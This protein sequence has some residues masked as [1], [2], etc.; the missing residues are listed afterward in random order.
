MYRSQPMHLVQ[1]RNHVAQH[2]SSN[3]TFQTVEGMI[4]SSLELVLELISAPVQS[5]RNIWT[6]C[7]LFRDPKGGGG[8]QHVAC[9]E[10]PRG[11]GGVGS[12]YLMR[13]NKYNK[14]NPVR[15][16]AA[17]ALVH[18]PLPKVGTQTRSADNS[19]FYL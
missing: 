14:H 1:T 4:A 2:E 13:G 12:C 6:T 10:V 8:G 16:A 3:L 19:P 9:S 5:K 18:K 17:R 15:A 11:G 7:G